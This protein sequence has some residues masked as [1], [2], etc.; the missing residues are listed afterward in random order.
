[1]KEA[2]KTNLLKSFMGNFF[3][4]ISILAISSFSFVCLL[5]ALIFLASVVAGGNMG[6]LFLLGWWFF[7]P[8]VIGTFFLLSPA[9]F[10]VAARSETPFFQKL[11]RLMGVQQF[12]TAG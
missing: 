1:M 12:I 7:I 5:F 4:Y 10:I 2:D 11:K 6:I 8:M 9:L 3:F